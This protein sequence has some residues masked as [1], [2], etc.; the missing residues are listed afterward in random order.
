MTVNREIIY[1][2]FKENKKVHLGNKRLINLP[3][4]LRKMNEYTL[5][6]AISRKMKHKNMIRNSQLEL[7]L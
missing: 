1:C 7:E 5:K 3:S 6:K 4:L 2:P